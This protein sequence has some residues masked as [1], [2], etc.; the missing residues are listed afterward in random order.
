MSAAGDDLTEPNNYFSSPDAKKN[1]NESNK[2]SQEQISF[3]WSVLFLPA[4][5]RWTVATAV[6]FPQKSESNKGTPYKD[7]IHA[8][9]S[10]LERYWLLG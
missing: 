6:G 4:T 5:V 8:A 2:G 7:S 3:G 1:A 9:F 10:V